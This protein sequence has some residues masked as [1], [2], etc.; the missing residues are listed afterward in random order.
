[1]KA[2]LTILSRDKKNRKLVDQRYRHVIELDPGSDIYNEYARFLRNQM[3]DFKRSAEYYEMAIAIS[4][5]RY[6]YHQNYAVLLLMDLKDY[7]KARTELEDVL[8]LD[9]GNIS[10]R[11]NYD[12]LLRTKFDAN[13]NPK[14]GL[15]SRRK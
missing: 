8:R 3:L 12:M 2:S 10:A 9:P 13:G 14:K 5:D 6:E 15:F 4:P 1:M 11:K 7:S